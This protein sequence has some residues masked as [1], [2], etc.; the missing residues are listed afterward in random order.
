M[1][2]LH[3]LGWLKPH[4]YW[5]VYH[6]FPPV[7]PISS[8]HR[9]VHL[10]QGEIRVLPWTV[11]TG[12][13]LRW[14]RKHGLDIPRGSRVL[15]CKVLFANI[16]VNIGNCTIHRASGHRYHEYYDPPGHNYFGEKNT[17]EQ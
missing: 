3:H 11:G 1:E 4:E 5:D 7:I 12:A 15:E 8:I 9:E 16:S 13:R 6:R 2:I 17:D 14:Y 10:P